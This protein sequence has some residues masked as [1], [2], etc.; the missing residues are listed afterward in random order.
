MKG[1]LQLRPI[2]RYHGGKWL[3]APWI[4][5]HFPP[6]I[7][8]VE[9]YGGA[10]SVLLRKPRV[11]QEIYNDLNSEI[12]N[13][14]RVMRDDTQNRRLKHLLSLTPFARDELSFA[15][16]FADDPVEN[17][18]RLVVRAFMGFGSAAHNSGHATGFRTRNPQGGHPAM[19]WKNYPQALDFFLERLRGVS[20]ENVP[21]LELIR[22]RDNARQLFY[23]DPPYPHITRK[24][25]QS[26]NYGRFEMSDA[27]HAELADCLHSLKG[28]CVLS[29]YPSP[30]YRRLYRGWH[31]VT[32]RTTGNGNVG[33]CARTGML[34]LNRACWKALQA[35]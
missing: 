16:Q 26:G 28:M 2:L 33:A 21:A 30:L 23:L 15:Y 9:P 29:S 7:A 6:H 22:R 24:H 12:V 1:N 19:D 34:W 10:G 18:R 5:S 35:G 20:I 8:Y 4:I 13:C 25:R 31:C 17:A 27:D 11:R 3:L 14:F 32:R